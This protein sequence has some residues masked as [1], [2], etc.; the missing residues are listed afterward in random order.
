[1]KIIQNKGLKY[2]MKIKDDIISSDE[3]DIN[4][5]I[6]E[7]VYDVNRIRLNNEYLY[8]VARREFFPILQEFATNFHLHNDNINDRE[9]YI[10]EIKS[11][12]YNIEYGWSMDNYYR[13]I[14]LP[15][16]RPNDRIETPINE[17]IYNFN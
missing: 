4:F 13:F 15:N 8:V 10:H 11:Q 3:V 5:D 17:I 2:F 12:L 7:I 6:T 14:S 16:F 1:M 9:Q